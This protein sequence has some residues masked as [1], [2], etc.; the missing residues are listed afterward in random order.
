LIGESD[1]FLEAI[2]KI[3][4]VASSDITVMIL[5]ETGTG[6]ELFA[7]A[8]HYTSARRD[9]PFVPVNCGALPDQLFENELFGHAKG[10]FTDA[11]SGELGLLAVA[12]GGTLFLD[13]VDAM[14]LPSQ[15]KLL[16]FLQDREYRPLGSSRTLVANVRVV[17]AS[18]ADLRQLVERKV[19]REDLYHRLNVVSLRI[20]A[21]RER[22]GDIPLLA[23]HL[24][25]RFSV[26]YGRSPSRFNARAMQK[27]SS[28]AWPGN[29]REL[30]GA[31]QRAIILHPPGILQPCDIDLP[32]AEEHKPA[33][34]NLQQAKTHAIVQF[35]R[36]FLANLLGE[37]LGNVSQAAKAAGKERR[38]FQRLLQ[39]HGLKG[40]AFR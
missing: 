15:V 16:R 35:E 6:K 29:V 38:A 5:G 37:H 28:Y 11:S 23:N 12:E 22:P 30:E 9:K 8:V 33:A 20:P 18:N 40:D 4:L 3:P 27:L 25:A 7:R 39:K 14:S 26:Q 2:E 24:L 10:A 36:T 21:L 17:A 31:I 19:F 1:A 34:A 13:E 32:S